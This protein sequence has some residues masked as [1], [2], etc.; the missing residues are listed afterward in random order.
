MRKGFTLIEMMIVVAII[1]IIAAIAI[2]SLIAAR[3]GS[4]E[5]NAV[6]ACRSYYSAQTMYRRND[7][8][9]D[10]VLEYAGDPNSTNAGGAAQT[11]FVALCTQTDSEGSEIKL[12]DDAFAAAIPGGPSKLGY[13]FQDMTDIDGTLIDWSTECALCALPSVYART[14]YRTFII[15]SNGTVFARDQGSAGTFL[16]TYPGDVA[17]AGWVIAE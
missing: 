6:G 9:G 8:D 5:T 15:C 14:G 4:L 13:N 3:R 1:A 17:A 11:G 2:P 10:T 12:I 7:W 16:N